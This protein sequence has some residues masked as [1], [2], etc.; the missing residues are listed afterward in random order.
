MRKNVKTIFT[1]MLSF[2]F[3]ISIA[4]GGGKSSDKKDNN[5]NNNEAPQTQIPAAPQNVQVT[6]GDNQATITWNTVS[7]ATSYNI[8][9]ASQ[10]GVK[11]NNYST[12]TDGSQCTN[13]TAS[14]KTLTDLINGKTY[15]IVVTAVNTKGE[16][17]E[18]NEA[19]AALQIPG[20]EAVEAG[21]ETSEAISAMFS[22]STDDD[23]Q[24]ASSG[25]KELNEALPEVSD[26]LSSAPDTSGDNTSA[27]KIAFRKV[28]TS[29]TEY[30]GPST[31]PDTTSG[32]YWKEYTYNN[33][34]W[35]LWIK[36]DPA[37]DFTTGWPTG[38]NKW[39]WAWTGESGAP[40]GYKWITEYTIVDGSR[41]T[42]TYRFEINAPAAKYVGSWFEGSFD[43][44]NLR[45]SIGAHTSFN[46]WKTH[47]VREDL[48]SV[49][50]FGS[51]RN[52]GTYNGTNWAWDYKWYY[53]TGTNTDPGYTAIPEWK[54]ASPS[55]VWASTIDGTGLVY[56]GEGSSYFEDGVWLWEYSSYRFD[57]ET[58]TYSHVRPKFIWNSGCMRTLAVVEGNYESTSEAGAEKMWEITSAYDTGSY[59]ISPIRYNALFREK[60]K[61]T[62][63]SQ[64]L[65]STGIYTI[66]LK[67]NNGETF[68]KKFKGSDLTIEVPVDG[69]D[70]PYI[71]SIT[72]EPLDTT[73]NVGQTVTYIA[74]VNDNYNNPILAQPKF[75]WLSNHENIASIDSTGIATGLSDG[76]ATITARV[77]RR[78]D[79]DGD[80]RISN[81]GGGFLDDLLSATATLTVN[82]VPAPLAPANVSASKG[83]GQVTINWNSAIGATSYNVYYAEGSTVTKINTKVT[84]NSLSKTIT[85]LTNGTL[86]SFAVTAENYNGE[87]DLSQIAT[88]TPN[89]S[90]SNEKTFGAPAIVS[91]N[92]SVNLTLSF[93]Y[94]FMN[95]SNSFVTWGNLSTPRGIVFDQSST[96]VQFGSDKI[97][98]SA[99]SLVGGSSSYFGRTEMIG[100]ENTIYIFFPTTAN[101]NALY[102]I[103]ST[104]GGNS[105]SGPL[106]VKT[107]C[108]APRIYMGANADTIYVIYMDGTDYKFYLISS[109]NGGQKWSSAAVLTDVMGEPDAAVSGND[110]YITWS[111]KDGVKF[112]K[113]TGA[114]QQPSVSQAIVVNAWTADPYQT[115]VIYCSKSINGGTSFGDRVKVST[116]TNYRAGSP[117]ITVDS[118]GGIHLAW[119][120]GYYIFM[121]GWDEMQRF[122]LFYAFSGDEAVSFSI[123]KQ[124][125][126]GEDNTNI[127]YPSIFENNGKVGV[128]YIQTLNSD[129]SIKYTHGE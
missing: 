126:G 29:S 14:P 50:S 20:E 70:I 93:N 27:R 82:P 58:H 64:N 76:T 68:K 15:Y 74:S 123:P 61:T 65:T 11:K 37:F 46:N 17:T 54:P 36:S 56:W 98:Y 106:S 22:S 122:A 9:S 16:S 32:W 83:D 2:L 109:T 66:I 94:L 75:T 119:I 88:A 101:P 23:S 127:M 53:G 96:G 13:V 5:D 47:W 72:V 95:N 10:T 124:I 57:G 34:T 39:W 24:S 107:K 3:A 6:H 4:C 62:V 25:S 42:G 85:G 125:A 92:T 129:Y 18:S 55:S 60:N 91:S 1:V 121:D 69:D 99:D 49:D 112:T 105:F 80:S 43:W 78:Y 28:L 110:L 33:S 59:I 104:D 26:A 81:I 51:Y 21:A 115:G 90:G 35:K 38:T 52:T 113:V 31:G 84:T 117:R 116:N 12:L 102:F 114:S 118:D 77:A 7:G 40:A 44:T 108:L 97:V 41:T 128:A 89:V 103:K 48:S 67:K 111:N 120:Q 87:S 30:S 45:Y 86:Y 100:H 79:F 8:Y 19:S 63:E 73:I 71:D